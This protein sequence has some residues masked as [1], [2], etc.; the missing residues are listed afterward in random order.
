MD[1]FLTR[2][3][4]E[5]MVHWSTRPKVLALKTAF[6]RMIPIYAMVGILS[7]VNHFKFFIPFSLTPLFQIIPFILILSLSLELTSTTSKETWMI[8]S[9]SMLLTYMMNQNLHISLGFMV[10]AIASTYLFYSLYTLL[11]RLLSKIQIESLPQKALINNVHWI[12][13][14]LFTGLTL[15]FPFNVGWLE[16]GLLNLFSLTNSV[17]FFILI[18]TLNTWSWYKG[19]HGTHVLSVWVIPLTGITILFN[20]IAF[21]QGQALP[22]RF[23]GYIY[24]VFGNYALFNAIQLWL[25]FKP[26][27]PNDSNLHRHSFLST[28]VNINEALIYSLPL[29]Q[30]RSIFLMF[31]SINAINMGLL[32][33]AFS[34]NWIQPFF[35]ASPFSIPSLVQSGL[36]MFNLTGSLVWIG[37]VLIDTVLMTPWMLK[38]RS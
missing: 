25:R 6:E 2:S 4:L 38:R 30:K 24:A 33:T 1:A 31:I 19:H 11:D 28:W 8:A 16:T 35:F 13:M 23:A 14:L 26:I 18:N 27:H 12:A 36:G 5:P 15:A 21:S 3:L 17:Y 32:F 34:L 9:N 37:I 20:L 29:V 22:Y 10:S 7:I